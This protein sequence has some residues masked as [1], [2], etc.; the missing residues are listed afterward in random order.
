MIETP[1]VLILGAGASKPYGYPLGSEL[2]DKIIHSLNAMV[3][4]ETGWVDELDINPFLVKQF[5]N[6]FNDSKRPSIDSFLA[7]Q[8]EEFV[9]IGKIA[10]VDA[11]SKCEKTEIY[12]P[13]SLKSY[14][15]MDE[16]DDWYSYFVEILY[17]CDID[18]INK[19]CDNISIISF[20]Y[21]RSLEY[22][23]QKPLQGTFKELEHI[24]D[25]AGIIQEIPIVHIFG[26]LDPLPWEVPW[27]D[28]YEKGRYYGEK[29]TSDDLLKMS[30]NIRLIHE[31]KDSGVIDKADYLIDKAHRVYFLGLDLYRNRINI[32]LFDSIPFMNLDSSI[33]RE[34]IT[35]GYGLEEGEKNHIRNYFRE[36]QGEVINPTYTV[37]DYKSL[38]TIRTH[39]P[40]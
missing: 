40:F 38:K 39:N 13:K 27:A 3:E 8:K 4:N 30:E 10:I 15:T 14:T 34:I 12:N 18:D 33:N 6:K 29:C 22:F 32:E 17:E 25:C 21:D 1:T 37:S 26:R 11:I 16:T 28:Q 24:E 19:I 9:E 35:T 20:N 31:T 36:L 7:K 23:L 5:T 2:K